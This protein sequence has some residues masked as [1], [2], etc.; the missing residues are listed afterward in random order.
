MNCLCG[1]GPSAGQHFWIK[2]ASMI[3]QCGAHSTSRV[4]W[5]RTSVGCDSFWAGIQCWQGHEHNVTEFYLGDVWSTCLMLWIVPWPSPVCRSAFPNK[6]GVHDSAVW[7][8]G[9]A[10]T[11]TFDSHVE[12][13]VEIQFRRCPVYF[14]EFCVQTFC[15]KRTILNPS[16][17]DIC[18]EG[19]RR[20][21]TVNLSLLIPKNTL[22]AKAMRR[23]H[24]NQL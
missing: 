24:A 18:S 9:G 22:F 2:M 23:C 13:F 20:R 17:I 21:A 11:S 10:S 6:Y 15:L 5:N 19:G 4:K 1:R 8:L 16:V 12:S 7:G 14:W 3:Q